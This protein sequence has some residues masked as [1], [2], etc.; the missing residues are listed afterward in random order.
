MWMRCA[1]AQEDFFNSDTQSNATD[2]MW[3]EGKTDV[4]KHYQSVMTSYDYDCAISE[5]GDYGQPG[6]GG[7]NMFQVPVPGTHCI[8]EATHLTFVQKRASAS[9][10][11]QLLS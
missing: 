11:K 8:S 2:V 10:S 6:I 5:A 3:S 1:G 9:C 4:Y 7:K